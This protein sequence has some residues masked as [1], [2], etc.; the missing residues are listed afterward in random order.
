MSTP[1]RVSCELRRVEKEIDNYYKANPL[2]TLPFASAALYLLARVE[3]SFSEHINRN[4]T[5]QQLGM[6]VDNTVNELKHSMFWIS[7]ECKPSGRIP[8]TFDINA[9]EAS[10]RLF[11]LG[12]RYEWFDAAFRY[13]S[14]GWIGLKLEGSTINPTEELF[15]DHR[16]RAYHYLIK[17]HES[18]EAVSLI[19]FDKIQL[20]LETIGSSAKV[21][22]NRLLTGINPRLVNEII[23]V[24][25]PSYDKVFSLPC[26]WEFTRYTL[27]D[28][29]K[30]FVAI[31]T[32]AFICWQTRIAAIEKGHVNAVCLNSIFLLTPNELLRRVARYSHLSDEKVL[33]IINDLT[34]RNRGVKHPDPALQPLIKLNSAYYAIMPQLWL[35]LSPE[36]NLTVLFNKI[37]SEREI[38]AKLVDEKEKLM[39]ERFI[40]DLSDKDFR[41]V[42][43]NV[44]NLSDVD[45]AIVSDSE[46]ACL[47]L[48]LKWFIDPA[49]IR[50]IIDRSEN[51]KDGICQVLKLKNAFANNHE[52]LLN[53]LK[54]D[55]SYRLEGVV[56]SQNWI[57]NSYI[58]SPE[59]PVIRSNHLKEK[60]KVTESLQSTMDWL[61][62]RKYLPKEGEHFKVHGI[63]STIGNWNLKWSGAIEPL[64]EGRFFPM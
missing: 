17:S 36:R 27:G 38:Y 48:E 8:S 23:K 34:Y 25:S 47:L 11:L 30:V 62:E 3:N 6:M 19:D 46:K 32:M 28:F 14:N 63:T 31:V 56:V 61:K 50:E 57:G 15:K 2:L 10:Y 52:P 18:D 58:Q 24:I 21:R 42:S 29:R 13:A 9:Y 7:T 53:K 5:S 41:F 1:D 49:E 35:S 59:V 4:L 12:R 64:I 37:P 20:L 40:T 54:I 60:L 22:G 43:E 26:E 45:L 44:A 39:Q 16:Y 51:I 55:S 33:N